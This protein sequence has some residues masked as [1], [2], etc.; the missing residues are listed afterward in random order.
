MIP[1]F[2]D[3][4]KGLAVGASKTFTVT[5]PEQYNSEKLAGKAAEFEIELL[6]VEE[7]VLPEVN[8]DFIKAYGVEEGDVDGFRSDVRANMEREL[9]QA[10]KGK[11]KN[12]VMDALFENI[13]INTPNALIDQEVQ[14]LMKPYEE[15]A[16]NMRL[17]L[18]DL[19]LPRD[20]FE[21][22][23]RRRVALGLILGEI[24]QKNEI[25]IDADSVRA[26]IEDMSKSYE[27]PED[28]VNWYYADKSRLSD[29]QQMVLEDQAVAW[30][31]SQAQI[32]DLTV[33]F[34]DVMEKR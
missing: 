12:A 26:V 3:E 27:R 5:F 21:Q 15:R 31:V 11:L 7:P 16:K 17:K 32:T 23:A 4:L 34:D 24:I 30:V 22:Q 25:K 9:A 19:N 1:G 2:E 10:L 14:A 29:V 13:A 8:E 6:K 33:G 20:T 18:E 28:V